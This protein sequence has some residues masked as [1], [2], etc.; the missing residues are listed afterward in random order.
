MFGSLGSGDHKIAVFQFFNCLGTF[1]QGKSG[2]KRLDLL[3]EIIYQIPGQDLGKSR[4]IIYGFFRV[5]FRTLAPGC[6]KAS[7]KW[8]LSC[9]NP[10]SKT[11][12]KP[13]GPAP[14]I[15]ISVLIME[16]YFRREW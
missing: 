16:C 10:A 4:D 8:H 15:N 6:A 7:I 3:H 14:M 9:N 13:V 2:L 1:P 11:A 12:N 5:E